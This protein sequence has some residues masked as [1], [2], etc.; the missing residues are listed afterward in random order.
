MNIKKICI[1]F[2]ISTY[3]FS[4]NLGENIM[5]DQSELY[6]HS[7]QENIYNIKND[8]LNKV[9]RI[10]NKYTDF[11]GINLKDFIENK[12]YAISLI[13]YNKIFMVI[14]A[15]SLEFLG[16]DFY[17]NS[18][19][20]NRFLNDINTYYNLGDDPFI[21]SYNDEKLYISNDISLFF[22]LFNYVDDDEDLKHD[23]IFQKLNNEREDYKYKYFIDPEN[24]INIE[25]Y[26]VKESLTLVYEEKVQKYYNI[27]Q[28]GEEKITK[29][30]ETYNFA[31][32]IPRDNM[33][34]SIKSDFSELK[35]EM[36]LDFNM[37]EKKDREFKIIKDWSKLSGFVSIK[38]KNG[39]IYEKDDSESDYYLIYSK[40]IIE[41]IRDNI[42]NLYNE[43]FFYIDDYKIKKDE[44]I[45][46]P[47]F[48][49]QKYIRI[50]DD[51]Y[52]VITENK[53]VLRDIEIGKYYNYKYSH[54]G[55]DGNIY[56]ESK[57][58]VKTKE[59]YK[60]N[61]GVLLKEQKR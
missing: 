1:F 26:E 51:N 10:L 34:V 7:A 43:N 40:E 55:N 22:D 56:E 48:N 45:F 33:G 25:S 23:E 59:K 21:Y 18:Q 16:S 28:E 39:N 24:P 15:P 8:D 2:V 35:E 49:I 57:S 14:K 9:K 47:L 38:V 37:L 12:E 20:D 42:I 54:I 13:D 41:E 44:D 29:R 31:D 5:P 61:N 27:I 52:L 17:N 58:E 30:L 60:V 3:I 11:K 6:F 32:Y 4:A 36:R 50:I 53:E 19:F 46:I